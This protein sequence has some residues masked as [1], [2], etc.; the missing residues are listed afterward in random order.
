MLAT[1]HALAEC[2]AG[3]SDAELEKGLAP[4]GMK[5]HQYIQGHLAHNSNHLCEIVAT[6]HM[7]GLWL[8]KT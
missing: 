7:Q 8:E 4:V 3:H 6:R 5:A 1:N 2:V